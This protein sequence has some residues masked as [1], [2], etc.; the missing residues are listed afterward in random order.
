M[1]CVVLAQKSYL[2]ESGSLAFAPKKAA[3]DQVT[4]E[5]QHHHTHRTETDFAQ[6]GF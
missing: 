3:D 6:R 1:V 4:G 5:I 2:L